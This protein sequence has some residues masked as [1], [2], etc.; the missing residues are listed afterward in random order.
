[1]SDLVITTS[2]T[3]KLTKWFQHAHRHLETSRRENW[4]W[5][6]LTSLVSTLSWLTRRDTAVYNKLIIYVKTVVD[7]N[8][9][10][11]FAENQNL[12]ESKHHCWQNQNLLERQQIS[13]NMWYFYGPIVPEINYSIILLY[14]KLDGIGS[15]V[16]AVM[17]GVRNGIYLH[18]KQ[19]YPLLVYIYHV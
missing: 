10:V 17:T 18:L 14:E 5:Q 9:K 7:A 2:T 4:V 3:N 11:V 15:D 6:K 19:I 13:Y 12:Q 8:S 1:M 16:A